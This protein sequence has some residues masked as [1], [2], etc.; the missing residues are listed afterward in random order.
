V[1][2]L[3]LL[4]QEKQN[5]VPTTYLGMTKELFI[6]ALKPVTPVKTKSPFE[7]NAVCPNILF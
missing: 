2:G 4:Q 6:S 3:V 5:Y 7:P 1:T